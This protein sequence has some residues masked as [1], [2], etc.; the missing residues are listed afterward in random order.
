MSFNPLCKPNEL[1]GLTFKEHQ[2]KTVKVFAKM[3]ING[4]T[5]MENLVPVFFEI[6]HKFADGPNIF[7]LAGKLNDWKKH[8]KN[9]LTDSFRKTNALKGYAFISGDE[10]TGYELNVAPVKG[11]AG[12]KK[13]K[14]L[15][16]D[17]KKL[18]KNKAT[19]TLL[20]AM[21]ENDDF[22]NRME[23][24]VDTEDNSTKD[25]VVTTEADNTSSSQEILTISVA[26][27]L[28]EAIAFYKTMASEKSLI[29]LFGGDAEFIDSTN[30]LKLICELARSFE[31]APQGETRLKIRQDAAN[32][33]AGHVESY[34]KMCNYVPS[35][36]MYK[37]AECL[38]RLVAKIEKYAIPIAVEELKVTQKQIEGKTFGERGVAGEQSASDVAK[39]KRDAGVSEVALELAKLLKLGQAS[40]SNSLFA[41]VIRWVAV[42]SA[43]LKAT[44]SQY[45]AATMQ[46]YKTQSALGADLRSVFKDELR[47][48]FVQQM[49]VD[50]VSQ[51]ASL[52][53]ALGCLGKTS[54]ARMFSGEKEDAVA[55]YSK[56]DSKALFGLSWGADPFAAA[57][58]AALSREQQVQLYRLYDIN[59]TRAQLAKAP[60]NSQEARELQQQSIQNAD[61]YLTQIT[62]KLTQEGKTLGLLG[63][64]DENK[65][66]AELEAWAETA[67]DAEKAAM[68]NPNSTFYKLL[69]SKKN[70]RVVDLALLT[71]N[72]PKDA[73]GNDKA[74]FELEKIAVERKHAGWF[75]GMS[76]AEAGRAVEKLLFAREDGL[77][78][79][80]EAIIAKF[81]PEG[82]EGFRK[83]DILV[84]NE[85]S[86]HQIILRKAIANMKAKLKEMGVPDSVQDAVE[87]SILSNGAQGMAYQQIAEYAAKDAGSLADN[88]IAVL[89][90]LDPESPEWATIKNAE[91]LLKTLKFN[92]QKAG[93]TSAEKLHKKDWLPI[94]RLL[95]LKGHWLEFNYNVDKDSQAKL[96]ESYSWLRKND[97]LKITT[98]AEKKIIA[99]KA[100]EMRKE[101]AYWAQMLFY[102]HD[103][104]IFTTDEFEVM[105][106]VMQAQRE[107]NWEEVLIQLRSIGPNA[108]NFILE[109]MQKRGKNWYDEVTPTTMFEI[110]EKED[111]MFTFNSTNQAKFKKILLAM[112]AIELIKHCFNLK[113]ISTKATAA[114]QEKQNAE[115]AKQQAT[116]P[117]EIE[118]ANE[119]IDKANENASEATLHIIKNLDVSAEFTK[120]LNKVFPI[121]I[122]FDL[123]VIIRDKVVAELAKAE[124]ASLQALLPTFSLEEV[125]LLV[126]YIRALSSN[127]K[128]DMSRTGVQYYGITTKGQQRD[129][130]A[131]EHSRELAK[132][133]NVLNSKVYHKM[134]PE[135]RERLLRDLN[136]G[137]KISGEE[138]EKT[139]KAFEERKKT[140]DNR[141]KGAVNFIVSAALKFAT[142]PLKTIPFLGKTIEAAVVAITDTVLGKI[143]GGDRVGSWKDAIKEGG[144]KFALDLAKGILSEAAPMILESVLGESG[145][146]AIENAGNKLAETR[147]K[148]INSNKV[149]SKTVD[150]LKSASKT[151]D[152][153]SV[154]Q[155]ISN[156]KTTIAE[157]KKSIEDNYGL[158][159]EVAVE[160][161]EEQVDALKEKVGEKVGT[162]TKRLRE[163]LTTNREWL[164]TTLSVLETA[165]ATYG[166]LTE[167]YEAI[168][169]INAKRRLEEFQKENPTLEGDELLAAL[170][171][172]DDF[173]DLEDADWVGIEA[174]TDLSDKLQE[175]FE[176]FF[177]GEVEGL[178]EGEEEEEEEEAEEEEGEEAEEGEERTLDGAKPKE[179]LIKL[180]DMLKSQGQAVPKEIELL[181]AS[182]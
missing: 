68:S 1:G 76:K 44:E 7:M 157:L 48:L 122:A 18:L 151:W 77:K 123:K 120:T 166:K 51:Y 160:I 21:E 163:N 71:I 161:V 4:H 47:G 74:M 45:A 60:E 133:Q 55:I 116:T 99:E 144:K 178:L 89:K 80:Q 88:V 10:K 34:I 137:L 49:L 167:A 148:I 92:I 113:E 15:K 156:A 17:F 57:A 177:S 16:I 135:D 29:P 95:G 66:F 13:L 11:D 42:A 97:R 149:L 37:Q 82:L 61:N 63:S 159:G 53:T 129:V 145:F 28:K 30:R 139:F 128:E 172:L 46:L 126:E 20:A 9:A 155:F 83:E 39:A 119:A 86:N 58:W 141:I 170:K 84:H 125:K 127:E 78:D 102:K 56:Y 165:S 36:T 65:L 31:T 164:E 90:G 107:S 153:S 64:L 24:A 98:E 94:A 108:Y 180:R 73:S 2:S 43:N 50:K 181:I 81:Y 69:L 142:I 140:Y 138:K 85:F 35:E 110:I 100:K 27:E 33:L 109:Y 87:E 41:D 173:K 105:N 19:L 154:G 150:G 112:D 101:P 115:A 106:T 6:E 52:A 38:R 175:D 132:V 25:Q 179:S 8:I 111:T 12:T 143:L 72:K 136:K 131:A 130:A 104:G 162:F 134:K 146:S 168:N 23:N 14:D 121:N 117:E 114:L 54:F 93:L 169:N 32:A 40:D 103:K 67:T 5:D 158:V 91:D 59:N 152:E 147:D 176:D 26:T 174:Y 3:K 182:L 96:A 62:E 22:E 171:E 70:Q 118:K 79:P 75:T 124:T